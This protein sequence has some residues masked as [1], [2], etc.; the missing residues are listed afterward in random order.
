MFSR[1]SRWMRSLPLTA[2][3]QGVLFQVSIIITF[4][5]SY[6]F[7]LNPERGLKFWSS[8]QKTR[9]TRFKH[10]IGRSSPVKTFRF[11]YMI[12]TN[13]NNDNSVHEYS[14]PDLLK[15]AWTRGDRKYAYFIT[16]FLTC[17]PFCFFRWL[18]YHD[19]R[20]CWLIDA[21]TTSTT[22]SEVQL[23]KEACCYG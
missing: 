9:S 1:H 7:H 21:K 13:M 18:L 3:K 8:V 12:G 5:D 15:T 2:T 4:N 14:S 20:Q 22:E 6:H 19:T 11:K 16:V 17:F 10:Y 23:L